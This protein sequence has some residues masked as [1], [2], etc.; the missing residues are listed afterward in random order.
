MMMTV[1]QTAPFSGL[2]PV[3]VSRYSFSAVAKSTAGICSPCNLLATQHAPCVFFY[4]V[5]QT[6]L[7]FGLWCF[8][9]GSFQIMVVRAGQPSGWPVSNKAG[10][11][12]PVRATTHEICSSGGGDNR[13]LLEVAPM[14]TTLTPSHP[15]FVFVFAAVRRADRKPRICML[16]TVA[17]DEHAARLSLVR[18]YVLS[19]AGRLPVAEVS[20]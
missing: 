3:A 15:Q 16:R 2:L 8:H 6:H 7:Y 17:G 9:H 18:N 10:T 5:A 11:A 1:Q 14:A 4:V 20:A 13:Y 19:F 12:N